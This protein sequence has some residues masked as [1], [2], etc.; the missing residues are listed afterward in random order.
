MLHGAVS[1]EMSTDPSAHAVPGARGLRS[2]KADGEGRP[3]PLAR[4]WYETCATKARFTNDDGAL[5]GLD[6]GDAYRIDLG[7]QRTDR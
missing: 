6:T 3:G 7:N 5:A 4:T 2:T 1:P